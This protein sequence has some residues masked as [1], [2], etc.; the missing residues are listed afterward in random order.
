MKSKSFRKKLS[1]NK[2]TIVNLNMIEMKESY[3]GGVPLS[4]TTSCI[5]S[6]CGGNCSD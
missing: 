2:K 3:A 1:L 5:L 6:G 4:F